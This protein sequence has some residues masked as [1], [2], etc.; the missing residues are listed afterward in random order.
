[1][2]WWDDEAFAY[3]PDQSGEYGYPTGN[4]SYFDKDRL[5]IHITAGSDSLGWL[6][7]ANGN[8]AHYLTWPDGS[9]RAQLL[10]ERVAAWAAGNQEYNERGI[11]LEHEKRHITDPWSDEEYRNLA[12]IAARI[13]QRN[14]LIKP[15]REHVIGH[16]EVP[17]PN[18]PGRFG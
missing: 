15:D 1:T 17:D 18:N 10:P 4:L 9:P 2:S 16:S 7:G 14:P 13:I 8:S 5:I 12:K 6:N 11:Q 3:I